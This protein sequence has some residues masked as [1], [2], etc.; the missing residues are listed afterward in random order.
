MMYN[1]KNRRYSKL[2]ASNGGGTKEMNVKILQTANCMISYLFRIFNY[3]KKR[4]DSLKKECPANFLP[5]YR[6]F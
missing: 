5:L 6:N 1:R 4:F 3:S 2:G